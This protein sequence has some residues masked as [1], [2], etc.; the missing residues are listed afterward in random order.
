MLPPSGYTKG[1]PAGLRTDVGEGDIGPEVRGK[2][3]FP[4]KPRHLASAPPRPAPGWQ[5]D[6][7]DAQ[8]RGGR[9]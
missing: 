7:T 2:D 1:L 9:E 4:Y 8:E 5:P 6:R 3:F